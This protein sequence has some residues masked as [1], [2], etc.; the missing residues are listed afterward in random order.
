MLK[1]DLKQSSLK[2]TETSETITHEAVIMHNDSVRQFQFKKCL[3][4]SDWVSCSYISHNVRSGTLS[5]YH[6]IQSM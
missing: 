5:D 2:T 1:A 6:M 3:K 4:D